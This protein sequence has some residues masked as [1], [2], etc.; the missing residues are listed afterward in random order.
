M[1]EECDNLVYSFIAHASILNVI[2]IEYYLDIKR[3][4]HGGGVPTLVPQNDEVTFVT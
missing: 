2:F 4:E 3:D 1:H